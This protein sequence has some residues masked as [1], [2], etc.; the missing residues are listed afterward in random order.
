M[1]PGRAPVRTDSGTRESAH[2]IQRTCWE[3]CG[4]RAQNGAHRTCLGVLSLSGRTEEAGLGVVDCVGPSGVG[5][6]EGVYGRAR[7]DHRGKGASR[8][9]E[10]IQIDEGKKERRYKRG[11]TTRYRVRRSDPSGHCPS[12]GIPANDRSASRLAAVS[13]F[14]GCPYAFN[15]AS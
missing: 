1:S 11:E 15:S 6:E 14:S 5:I 2:P 10:S 13:P 3:M 9:G 8:Q 7:R 4:W 12:S